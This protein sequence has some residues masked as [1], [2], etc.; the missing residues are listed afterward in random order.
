MR[1]QSVRSS[2]LRIDLPQPLGGC[3]CRAADLAGQ[4]GQRLAGDAVVG[5]ARG[6][7]T[8]SGPDVCDERGEPRDFYYSRYNHPAGVAAETAYLDHT[9]RWAQTF[10]TV[11]PTP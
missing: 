6:E 10:H 1:G 8:E 5:G 2:Q 11:A 9:A 7:G 4:R 3:W